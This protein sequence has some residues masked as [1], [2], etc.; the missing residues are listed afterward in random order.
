LHV[1]DSTERIA[2]TR[3][4]Q[5]VA[6]VWSDLRLA[7][8]GTRHDYTAGPVGRAIFLLAVPMVL[9]MVME[10][11]FAVVDVFWVAKLGADA[12]A[13][14]GLTESMMS[15]VYTLAFGLAIGATATVA[16]RIGEKD[17][18]AAARSAVQAIALA[19]LASAALGVAGAIFAPQL[20]RIM[21]ASPEVLARGASFTRVMLGGSA[22]VF[23]LFVI[24]A[25]FR[26]A[27]DAA[28]AMR[29]LW[30]AN[31]INIVLGPLLIFGIGPF[32]RMGVTGAAIATTIGRGTGV[33]F[34]A[35]RLTHDSGHLIVRRSHLVIDV[36][37]MIRLVRMSAVGTFQ[38]LVGSTAWIGL[39]RILAGM[40]SVA[41]AGYT[42]AIRM[43]IFAILPA[44]GL[45][46][47]AATMVGQNLGARNADRAEQA[48]WTAARY[49]L[50]FLGAL[51]ILFVAAAPWITAL[52][53]RDQGVASVASLGLR[54]IA[55][56]FPFYAYGMVL[57][58]SFN[59]A[60]DT[61]TP[62]WINIGV[63][64]VAEI[65]FAWWLA[66]QTGFG[67]KGVFIAIT[68]AY[69]LLALVSAVL[70][71]QGKWKTRRV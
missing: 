6:A 1:S 52:F 25:V 71:R 16:R 39:I 32:P 35:S 63:F 64:W 14:V 27:G 37:A 19:I 56:G 23:L 58:Q 28:V 26:G 30:L 60:G 67:P 20:L 42:I 53:T 51:G 66:A 61:W 57:T 11:V 3:A 40:G 43:V 5:R 10:S 24:N 41:V 69:S 45:S 38:I 59:G 70:F 17:P 46:N 34:A 4:S 12:V 36:R 44:F 8:R 68:A 48:V 50:V 62:T 31:W 33:L 22:S 9:E 2:T 54:V 7:A 13:T 65:P 47:A 18:D 21:G 29:V 15:I 55:L 49:N